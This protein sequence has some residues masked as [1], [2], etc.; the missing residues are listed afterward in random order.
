MKHTKF[1][2]GIIIVGLVGITYIFDSTQLI[3]LQKLHESLT[4][5]RVFVRK[6]PLLSTLLYF[7]IYSI[8]SGLSLPGAAV[9][10]L[11]GGALFGV[12]QG[13]FY[14][15]LGATSGAILAFLL[16]RYLFENKVKE[17]YKNRFF[18]L[19]K[20][21]HAKGGYYLLS[22]RLIP[23]IPFFLI[24]ILAAL[25]PISL[26]TFTV[27]TFIGI[28]PGS[29]LYAY[30]GHHIGTLTSLKDVIAPHYF[31]IL[32]SMALVIL[33]VRFIVKHY[34]EK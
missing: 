18:G 23:G 11:A 10:T 8:V 32:F 24:N 15:V 2:I 26:S 33:F 7:L 3:S 21:L 14:A 34:E 25:T 31:V 1:L 13:T 12:Y 17:Q 20:E 19:Y 5:L 4:V 28:I 9:L 16:V 22:I 30:A 27:T 6:H 29:F